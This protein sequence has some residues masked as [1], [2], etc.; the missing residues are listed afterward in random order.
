MKKYNEI[1]GKLLQLNENISLLLGQAKSIPGMSECS[2]KNWEETCSTI[3]KQMADDILKIAV[4]GAIKSGKS[5][6]TNSVFKGDYLKRGAGVVT[7]IVTKIR[8]S[9]DIKAVL[10]FKSWEQVNSD[11][12]QSLI[13]FPSFNATLGRQAFDIKNENDRV[14]L[15][16]ALDCLSVELIIPDGTHDAN[17]LLLANYL[18]GFDL[19]KDIISS[20]NLTT[21]YKDHE[22]EAHKNFVGNDSLSV[23]LKDIQLEI[24][25][26]D[27]PEGIEIADCQGSDSPNPLH[28]SMIQEYLLQTH[29][30]VYVISSRTGIR[31]ADIKFLSMIKKMGIME[32]ILF[33]I[34][35]DFSEHDS[36]TDLNALIK[37]TTEQIFLIKRDPEVFTFSALYNLFT[38]NFAQ[39]TAKER[40]RLSQWENEKDFTDFS[41]LRTDSFFN[42][43]D[44]KLTAE[45]ASLF[46]KNHLARM[47]VIACG[48]ESW[49]RINNE[50][51]SK[52]TQSRTE[53]INKIKDSR[54]TINQ[55]K[56]TIKSAIDGAKLKIK[57][58][59]KNDIDLVF[60]NQ[61]QGIIDN[62][63]KFIRDYNVSYN[64][65]DD[66]LKKSGFNH[67]LYL[68]FNEFKQNLDRYIAE[69]VNPE[70]IRFIISLEHK[71]LMRFQGIAAPFFDMARES[72]AQ[73]YNQHID[74]PNN[75][76]EELKNIELPDIDTIKSIAGLALPG[77]TA[78]IN[79]SAKVKTQAFISLF[80]YSTLKIV[81][82]VF[83]KNPQTGEHQ[84]IAALK[85]GVRRMKQ[86]VET[87]VVFCFKSYRENTKFQYAFKLADAV[88]DTLYAALLDRFEAYTSDFSAIADTISKEKTHKQNALEILRQIE[89]GSAE[90]NQ[91][92]HSITKEIQ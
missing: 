9:P 6:F 29:L 83:K 30:I 84:K 89:S 27:I 5:T 63:I 56:S 20:E 31:Q 82:K 60:Q 55:V 67:A 70:I 86:E 61:T 72:L 35:S 17:S 21:E 38:H 15:Q 14:Q 16:Q 19:V 7:S 68:V 23:Y 48:M 74:S 53:T 64:Q 40:S 36:L 91:T 37:K 69:T 90:I 4:V 71:T 34:N 73:C 46:L 58:E 3:N 47:Q 62:T 78:S 76:S 8:K 65:Y 41:D 92:I 33:V 57:K 59:L 2:F 13:L 25:S 24:N 18:K 88:S 87:S 66:L 75:T 51:L 32:N 10:Y 42:R 49:I 39:L 45:R 43:L 85:H 54:N 81:K 26:G 77:I 12:N 50:I 28:L 80:F 52:D 1:K 22:F 11:I 79:Y 44:H